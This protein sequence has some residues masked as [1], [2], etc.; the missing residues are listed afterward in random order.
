MP[1]YEYVCDHCNARFEARVASWKEADSATCT[2]CSGTSLK[3]LVSRIAF[4]P[5][6]SD[7][8]MSARPSGSAGGCCG[9]A[10]GCGH[11]A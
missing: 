6:G 4:M 11:K 1:V 5:G 7:L 3:R 9:G 2:S 10:C 8:R